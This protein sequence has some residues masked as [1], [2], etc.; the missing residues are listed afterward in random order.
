MPHFLF[1]SFVLPVSPHLPLPLKTSHDLYIDARGP[2]TFVT[3]KTTQKV[4]TQRTKPQTQYR[5][6]HIMPRRQGQLSRGTWAESKGQS[7]L[8]NI[9]GLLRVW[10]PDRHRQSHQ[11]QPR[12]SSHPSRQQDLA[13]YEQG[14]PLNQRDLP[15]DRASVLQNQERL[16]DSLPSYEESQYHRRSV[17]QPA[18]NVQPRYEERQPAWAT[19]EGEPPAHHTGPSFQSADVEFRYQRGR[20]HGLDDYEDD[21]GQQSRFAGPAPHASNY[22]RSRTASPGQMPY[23]DR[24]VN[25]ARRGTYGSYRGEG[26]GR[27]PYDNEFAPFAPDPPS[28]RVPWSP[29]VQSHQREPYPPSVG[30]YRRDSDSFHEDDWTDDEYWSEHSSP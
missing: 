3:A 8:L 30:H 9:P 28:D 19:N 10:I 6:Q 12:A 26:E 25:S 29:H 4:T 21:Y 23:Q 16:P 13:I 20:P 27:P 14:G 1:N 11:G 24:G 7:Y 17:P 2:D 18:S 5:Q 15:V 22:P